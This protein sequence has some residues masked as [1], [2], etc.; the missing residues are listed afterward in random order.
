MA[1][2][3]DHAELSDRELWECAILM[4]SL[5]SDRALQHIV[6]RMIALADEGDAD[7]VA[8]W[9]AV[10]QRCRRLQETHLGPLP[11]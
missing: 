1:S 3:F 8:T 5:Y 11:I 9:Q 4:E 7:G 6:D 2:I 10:A